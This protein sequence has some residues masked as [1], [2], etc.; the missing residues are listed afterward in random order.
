MTTRPDEHAAPLRWKRLGTHVSPQPHALGKNETLSPSNFVTAWLC[1]KCLPWRNLD[2]Q[3]HLYGNCLHSWKNCDSGQLL[4]DTVCEQFPAPLP[5]Y[6]TLRGTAVREREAE[7]GS[8]RQREG[9]RH[10]ERE[11]ATERESQ[12]HRERESF[13]E[14]LQKWMDIYIF[15]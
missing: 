9:V 13:G 4:W 1:F 11:N 7:G 3:K 8:Q 10:S 5:V 6:C 14:S 2:V 15:I 12:R